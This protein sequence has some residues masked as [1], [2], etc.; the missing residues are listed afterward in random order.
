MSE[1][2]SRSPQP[3]KR[4]DEQ[5]S[6]AASN[7]DIDLFIRRSSKSPRPRICQSKTALLFYFSWRG[8]TKSIAH[9]AAFFNMHLPREA[10]RN[11]ICALRTQIKNPSQARWIFVAVVTEKMPVYC[12]FTLVKLDTTSSPEPFFSKMMQYKSPF[13]LTLNIIASV[14]LVNS[15]RVSGTRGAKT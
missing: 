14:S 12:S 3:D 8:F 10:G 15:S 6:S 13:I 1:K 5:R 4:K 11:I 2:M 7:K 9:T